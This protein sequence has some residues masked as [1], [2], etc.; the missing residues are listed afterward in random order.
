M[1]IISTTS[2]SDSDIKIIRFARFRDDRGYFTEVARYSDLN[3][4]SADKHLSDAVF[5]QVNESHSAKNVFRG[6]HF[7]WNPHLGKLVRATQGELIDIAVDI[8]RDSPNFGRAVLHKLS[9]Q[10]Q[11]DFQECLW[12]PP[13]FAHGFLSMQ[14]ETRIEYMCTGIWNNQ[15]ERSISIHDSAIDYQLCDVTLRSE[16][17]SLIK[18][19]IVN[20]KDAN[21]LSLHDW[22]ESG[23]SNIFNDTLSSLNNVS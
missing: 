15:C 16:F 23:D 21:G 10:S 13:G 14:D 17:Q 4:L 22:S 6:L 11:D 12:I 7:Q 8:R 18:E 1:K 5:Q 3:K 9:Y 20:E 19:A 2:V